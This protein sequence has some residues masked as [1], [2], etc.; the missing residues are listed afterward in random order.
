MA[1]FLSY[2]WPLDGAFLCGKKIQGNQKTMFYNWGITQEWQF[3]KDV[4]VKKWNF[5]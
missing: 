3:E 2:N 5:E 1:G 4:S